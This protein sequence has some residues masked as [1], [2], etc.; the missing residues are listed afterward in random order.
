[1]EQPVSSPSVKHGIGTPSSQ[2]GPRQE[3]T[4]KKKV[5]V[6]LEKANTLKERTSAVSQQQPTKF[7]A[8]SLTNQNR[9]FPQAPGLMSKHTSEVLRVRATINRKQTNEST[10]SIEA[11]QRKPTTQKRPLVLPR[12]TCW[13]PQFPKRS[14]VYLLHTKPLHKYHHQHKRIHNMPIWRQ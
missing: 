14:E 6:N 11:T 2:S 5:D 9:P 7:H 4:C 10:T 3:D 1:M 12:H 8:H 13:Q